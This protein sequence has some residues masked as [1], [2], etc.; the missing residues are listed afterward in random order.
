ME[1][2]EL[3]TGNITFDIDTI[4]IDGTS[5]GTQTKVEIDGRDWWNPFD[6]LVRVTETDRQTN[7]LVDQKSFPTGVVHSVAYRGGGDDLFLNA[8]GIHSTAYGDAGNDTLQ[9]GSGNDWLFGGDGYDSLYGNGG[10]DWSNGDNQNDWLD[11]GDGNDL[12]RF[13]VDRDG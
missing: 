8:T 1:A 3:K 9:G 12:V 6:D 2:R 10:D 11:G 4:F 5:V 7:Q 13:F